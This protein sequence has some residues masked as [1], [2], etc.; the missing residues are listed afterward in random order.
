MRSRT[1]VVLVDDHDVLRAGLRSL[2]E[3]QEAIEVVAEAGD[4]RSAIELAARHVPDV[5]LID[6][7]MGGLN[8][9]EATRRIHAADPLVGIIALTMHADGRYVTGMFDAGA[10]GY[11]LKTC[12]ADELLRAI[13]A[14]R[15]GRTYVTADVAHVVVGR[16]AAGRAGASEARGSGLPPVDVLTP[17]EREVLQCIAEGLTSR[18]IAARQLTS[19]KTAETH[20][21]NLM[22]KLGLHGIAA[23]TRYAIR[24]GVTTLE[25]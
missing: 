9:L 8:G 5:V 4:G 25:G 3:R 10:R 6:I 7:G 21:T 22:R 1:T 14:V 11:L 24:E 17:K 2:L 16:G 18:E 20:R 19:I 12:D 15:H 23:L 13:D